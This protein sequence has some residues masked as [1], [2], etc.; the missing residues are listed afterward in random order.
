MSNIMGHGYC[1]FSLGK[2]LIWWSPRAPGVSSRISLMEDL[3][4]AA[5]DESLNVCC[6]LV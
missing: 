5:C 3:G 1:S 2:N 6:E 4:P